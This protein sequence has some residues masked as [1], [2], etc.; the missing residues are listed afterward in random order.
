MNEKNIATNIKIRILRLI[1]L[2]SHGFFN[3]PPRLIGN[4][5]VALYDIT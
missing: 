3:M 1:N 4:V 5:P 2:S